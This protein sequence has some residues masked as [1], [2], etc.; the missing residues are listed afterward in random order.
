MKLY[1]LLIA[2]QAFFSCSKFAQDKE[3][4]TQREE[5]IKIVSAA[6]EI[7]NP[8]SFIID[9][10]ALNIFWVS[11][12]EDIRNRNY[13]KLKGKIKFPVHLEVFVPFQFAYDCD[14]N[15]FRRNEVQYMEN[16]IY[17]ENIS[18]YFDFMFCDVLSEIILEIDYT[19][20]VKK[21]I[22][23]KSKPA[24]TFRIFPKDFLQVECPSDHALHLN[25]HY[26]KEKWRIEINGL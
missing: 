1:G 12:Q 2:G 4:R 19:D 10:N 5:A 20:L 14:T 6:V 17:P 16:D 13:E 15:K 8:T 9:S 22:W 25:F 11:F 3:S 26:E 23:S 24:L 18:Q 21:G 7:I